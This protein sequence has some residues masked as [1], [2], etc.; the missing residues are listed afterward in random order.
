IQFLKELRSH[1]IVQP[2]KHGHPKL[3]TARNDPFINPHNRLQLQGWRANIDLKSVLTTY[4]ALQ[5]I[6]KYASKFEL[7]SLG[8][9]EI[10]DRTLRSSSPDK[11]SITVFQKLL[12]HTVSEH[13]YS[14]QETCHLLLGIPLY[15][16]ND[17]IDSAGK[18]GFLPLQ[19]YWSRPKELYDY[20]QEEINSGYND[21]IGSVVDSS[22]EHCSDSSDNDN[23]QEINEDEDEDEIRPISDREFD[24]VGESQKC[25]PNLENADS[26]IHEAR[27]A[28]DTS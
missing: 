14:V 4:A 18:T 8:F 20:Y 3:I 24:W 16:Y 19:I 6:S 23:M 13:D 1:T 9:S 15:Q 7:R 27:S 21:L 25:Y 28:V 11:P 22:E 2:D 5:Y 26:F 12:L 17:E 10:L